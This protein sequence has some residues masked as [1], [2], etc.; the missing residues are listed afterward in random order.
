MPLGPVRSETDIRLIWCGCC[1]SNSEGI[2]RG[3]KSIDDLISAWLGVKAI[4]VGCVSRKTSYGSLQVLEKKNRKAR[5]G[6]ACPGSR[7]STRCND[8][9]DDLY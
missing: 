1:N 6:E 8:N 5:A 3:W 2:L 9:R 7:A 4:S